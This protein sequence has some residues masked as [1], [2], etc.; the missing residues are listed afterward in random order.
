MHESV[1]TFLSAFIE[2]RIEG[3]SYAIK[4][5]TFVEAVLDFD[6]EETTQQ[7]LFYRLVDRE[8]MISEGRKRVAV[9][10]PTWHTV[11]HLSTAA[12]GSISPSTVFYSVLS[13]YS[14]GTLHWPP[15]SLS[16]YT[17]YSTPS[18]T[19]ASPAISYAPHSLMLAS[20]CDS[21]AIPTC[22]LNKPK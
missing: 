20:L 5:R 22:S 12:S 2:Q 19:L 14:S 17:T 7:G 1:N 18:P 16:S 9:I 3:V 21:L 10:P 11:R 6:F 15:V 13:T 8:A 4:D